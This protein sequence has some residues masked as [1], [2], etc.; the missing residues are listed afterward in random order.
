MDLRESAEDRAFRG[1]V[2]EWLEANLTGDFASAR[3]LGGPGREHEALEI[4][5]AWEKHL[6]EAGWTCIGWPKEYGGRDLSLEQQVIFHE[7]YAR[8]DAPIRVGL[9]G[10]GMVGPTLLAFGTDDQKERFLPGI[11]RGEQMWCQFYSEPNAGSDLAN[12]STRAERAGDDSRINGQ[13]VW[14]SLAAWADWG[15]AI[16]RT[17]PGSKRH[18]GLSYLL[19]PVHQ[20]GIEL[21]PIIQATGTSE[22]SEV[23]FDGARTPAANLVGAEG[24]GWKVGM[25]TLGFERGTFTLGQQVGF[26]RELERVIDIADKVGAS[27]DPE[28]RQRLARAWTGVSIMRW[29]ALRTLGGP[30]TAATGSIGKLFWSTW[31][32]ELGQLA[33][34]VLGMAGMVV[35]KPYELTPEQVTFLFSRADTIY[36]GSSEVQR[37]IIAERTLGLPREPASA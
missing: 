14:S 20:D 8:A 15:F 2:R 3:G 37:N 27:E 16:V 31:H 1:E 28:I 6:G 26:Q 22:F 34:D 29:N 13:K 12:V 17:E 33:M 7:E 35:E 10:E 25:A 36:A 24:D 32:Q 21:R 11:R 30:A 23:F 18:K 5:H 9:I 4:R 19:V